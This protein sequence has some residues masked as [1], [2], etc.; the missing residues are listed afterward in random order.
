LDS[1]EKQED[2]PKL[3][4]SVG[5]LLRPDVHKLINTEFVTRLAN[6]GIEITIRNPRSWNASS[7]TSSKQHSVKQLKTSDRDRK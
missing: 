3:I 7:A 2:L 1:L 6:A 5:Y 4:S